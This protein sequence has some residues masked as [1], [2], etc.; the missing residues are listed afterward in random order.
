MISGYFTY[1]KDLSIKESLIKKIKRLLIPYFF[2][3]FIIFAIR[4]YYG[5]WFLF[6]LF[7]LSI[8]AICLTGFLRIFNPRNYIAIDV[9]MIFILYFVLRKILNLP[10]LTNQFVDFGKSAFYFL[11]FIFGYL[12]RKYDVIKKAVEGRFSILLVL[13]ILLFANKYWIPYDNICIFIHLIILKI[14]N[15]CISI[16]GSLLFWELFRL[17]INKNIENILTYIGKQSL[18]IYVLH[19]I[20]IL[21]IKEVGAFWLRLDFS[22]CLTFQILYSLLVASLAAFCSIVLAQFIRRSALFSKLLFGIN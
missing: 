12:M 1:G 16:I 13:F 7:E 20:F 5:Y 22:T 11:P 18:E 2:S 6:S 4:G 10:I 3:G 15:Y 17:G 21:Q 14:S 8:I 9:I 19:I